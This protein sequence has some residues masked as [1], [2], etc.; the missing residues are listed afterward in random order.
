[1]KSNKKNIIKIMKYLKPYRLWITFS[2][3]TVFLS[4]V[5]SISVPYIMKSLMD[6]AV[7]LKFSE[8]LKS[9]YLAGVIVIL[10]SIVTY[11]E[12]YYTNL[13]SRTFMKDMKSHISSHI[14]NLP[15]YILKKYESGDIVSRINNDLIV[16]CNFFK[17]I[18]KLIFEPILMIISIVYMFIISW[19]LLLATVILIPISSFIFNKINK[20]IEK[21]SKD[22][23]EESSIIT[24]MLQE[25]I[26]GINVIKAFNLKETMSLKFDSVTENIKTKSL[27][28]SKLN[29]YITP[30][31]LALRLIPQ[32]VC[33]LYGGYLALNGEITLGQLFAFSVLIGYVFKP[34]ESILSF[35]SELRE[36]SPAFERI[37][38]ILDESI[39]NNN[40]KVAEVNSVLNPLEFNNVTFSYNREKT[41]LN[42]VCF[43]IKA[44]TTTA[45]VGPSGTGKSTILKLIC[46]FY[47]ASNGYINIYGQNIDEC[48]DESVRS[49]ITYMSQE[50]YMYPLTIA[51]NIGIGRQGASMDEIINAAKLANAH[52]FIIKMP[53]GYN[54]ILQERGK[55]LSGGQCQ[56]ISLARMIIKD[57]PIVL[58]D[59][60]TSSLDTQSE[61]LIQEAL[62]K[63]TVNKTV[64]VVAHRL[65]TIKAA[66][67]ILV[68]NE[69]KIAECGTHNE[70]M[71]KDSLY[72]KLFI[73][74]LD[75]SE[76]GKAVC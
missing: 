49:L 20:P 65:S 63:F 4:T 1:M 66:N 53:E 41:I 37:L 27:K 74:Q 46:K 21:H 2:I 48:T 76:E 39:E 55:N 32:L 28:I 18:P 9:L 10:G 54:T 33:P 72:K 29:A 59:E 31:F 40:G 30:V 24:A 52:D 13:Y 50:S 57:A 35:L 47:K 15:I 7:N 69:D 22:L 19:K 3:I 64:V 70:L 51:E 43:K 61:A 26:G 62:D 67:Q 34:V 23:M 8:F 25:V 12:K 11:F 60:P 56:R 16:V 5:C 68:L 6:T 38:E 17:G 42:N 75:L 44:G 73:N 14:Q 36:S 71:K 45:I 58:L